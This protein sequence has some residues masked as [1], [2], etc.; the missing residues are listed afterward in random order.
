MRTPICDF[1]AQYVDSQS[2]RLH[3][4]G[5]KGAPV[6]GA[7]PYD[8][9]EIP[10]ADVLY[11]AQG[12]I[13]E[14][15][16]NAAALFGTAVSLYSTEGS[17]LC[18]R[19]MLYLV[20]LLASS[21]GRKPRLL[22]ARNAH[23]ALL[24]A[25]ALLNVDVDWVYADT[26][27]LLSWQPDLATLEERLRA[28]QPVAL[29]ITS[30][31]YLGQRCDIAA[32]A[33][34]CHRYGTLLLVDN[35]HGAYL[36]FLSPSCH[37]MDFGADMC[38]DSAHKT[39]PVLTGGAYLHIAKHAPAL[40]WEQAE[41]AF[42]LFASTSPSYLVLQSLDK[43]NACLAGEYPMQLART[44]TAVNEL[45]QGMIAHGYTLR[46]DEPLKITVSTKP[47][48]YTGTEF[49]ALLAREHIICEFADPDAV[50]MMLSPQLGAQQMARVREVLL[51]IS[52][53]T[54]IGQQPPT[55]RPAERVLSPREALLSPRERTPLTQARGKVLAT[56]SVTCPPAVPILVCGERI[57]EQAIRCMQYY[58]MNACDTV[59]QEVNQ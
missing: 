51:S 47:F 1:V 23:K 24:Y 38:C 50:V 33:Q 29:Y 56:V 2:I 3:M 32:L 40:L 20:R 16:Q 21:Q 41:Q 18:I 11:E 37:P 22:A 44:V 12:I 55:I 58:G 5:H 13:R 19:A 9:T 31:D 59:V 17:S 43:A 34:L 48:G 45:K 26:G 25:A 53:R 30:P 46:G 42:S 7:E 57:S 4:P 10:G 6:L 39:L 52:P 49:A 14:S 35:A 15:E 8:I 54:P 36:K 28:E 27:E